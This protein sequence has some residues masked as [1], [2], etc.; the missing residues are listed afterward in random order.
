MKKKKDSLERFMEKV[1]KS[2]TG[3]WIWTGCN[4]RDLYGSFQVDGKS[5][6]AHRWIYEYINGPLGELNC[7]HKC[8]NPPCVNPD[9]LESGTQIANMLYR[10]ISGNNPQIN[11]THCPFGHEYTPENTRMTKKGR[12]CQACQ[13]ERNRKRYL[14]K[15]DIG[16]RSPLININESLHS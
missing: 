9:H 7:M 1:F 11:K 3:C 2:S 8:N 14:P 6:I 13:D 15:L 12:D 16:T 5:V 10:I 4:K